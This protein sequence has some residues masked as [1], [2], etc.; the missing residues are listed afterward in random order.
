MAIWRTEVDSDYKS[1]GYDYERHVRQI[2]SYERGELSVWRPVYVQ[3]VDEWGSKH[4][5]MPSFPGLSMDIT[6]GEETK[7]ILDGLLHE[8]VDFLPLASH[9]IRDDQYYILFPRTILDC[10][11]NELSEFRRMPSG[12]IVG[13][14]KY[15]FKPDC[16]GATPI[17]R[18]PIAG[19]PIGEPYVND[20]FKQ[21]VEDHNLTGLKFS[22]VW[23]G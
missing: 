7:S 11:D 16:I 2:M 9:T 15:V 22:K 12:Y 19:S 5:R 10:L 18:L 20:T 8:H 17:F 4:E 3:V 14:P 13:V 6:C 1:L 23:E 21:L